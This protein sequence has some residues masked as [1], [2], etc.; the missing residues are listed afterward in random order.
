MGG[1]GLQSP[2]PFVFSESESWPGMVCPRIFS[3]S[4]SGSGDGVACGREIE[5]RDRPWMICVHGEPLGGE[6]EA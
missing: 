5:E 4:S 2:C 3:D 6:C 1:K